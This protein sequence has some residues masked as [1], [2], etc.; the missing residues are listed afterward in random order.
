LEFLANRAGPYTFWEESMKYNDGTCKEGREKMKWVDAMLSPDMIEKLDSFLEKRRKKS[1]GFSATP[2]LPVTVQ[3]T[4]HALS[5]VKTLGRE[6]EMKLSEDSALR[7]YLAGAALTERHD[8]KITYQLLACCRM[9]G[10]QPDRKKAEAF[11]SRRLSETGDQEERYYCCRIEREILAGVGERFSTLVGPALEWRFRTASE[12]LMLLYQAAK[13][14]DH[15]QEL[16]EWL[17]SCQ[18]YD[19]G[20]GFLPGTTSFVENCFDCLAALTLLAATPRDPSGCRDYILACRT[21]S[22]G[23]ARKNKAV[24]FLSSTWHAV[25]ALSLLAP[26]LKNN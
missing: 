4:Y 20:F 22:G 15:R 11:I 1:G 21:G 14:P 19:G 26:N 23:C 18:G 13:P 5:I 24:A 16:V 7:R 12:L 17:Q 25:A 2:R 8:A 3:D 9:I 6:K 10:M